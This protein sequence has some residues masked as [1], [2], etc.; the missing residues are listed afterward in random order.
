M[1]GIFGYFGKNNAF[2][3][4]LKGLK[5]LEYRGYDS[6]GIAVL[7]KKLEIRKG[8]GKV[9]EVFSRVDL[10]NLCGNIGIAHTRW[11]THGKVTK[12][13]A[14]PHLS[15]NKKVAVVHN[16]I[17]ENYQELKSFLE[18][19]GFVFYTETDT[20]VIPNLIEYEMRKGKGFEEACKDAFRMLEGSYAILAIHEDEKKIIETCNGSPLVIGVGEDEYFAASDIPAFLEFTPRVIYLHDKDF[21]VI[22]KEIKFFNLAEEKE[23]KRE[24]K[25]VEWSLEEVKKGNFEHYMLKEI[26]EQVET[27]QRAINQD[28]KILMEVAKSIREA[29]GVFLI[30]CG[31]S[32]HACLTASYLFS[33]IAKMHVNP[34]LA[35][36]FSNYEDFL[37]EKTLVIA[38]SQSG[39]TA[40]VLEAVKTAKKKGSKVISIVNVLGSS[41]HRNSDQALLMNAGPEICVLSTK[42]YTS[43]LVILTL[44]AYALAGKYEE[45]RK[46]L[47]YLWNLIYNLTSESTREHIKKL[48]EKLKDKEHLFLIGRGLQYPTALEAA[49][50]IKEVSYIH[51]EAFA[52]GELKHGTIALIENG[53]PCIVFVSEENE[54]EIIA[55]AYEIKARGGYIIGVSS[56]RNEIFDFWI[57]VPEVGETNPIC[58]IIPIQI[59]AYQLAV[60]RC[61][62]PDKPRN[63]AKSVTVK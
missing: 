52:G 30:G 39:E 31:T 14:H 9:D 38:V 32:Y 22:D 45:G 54:K 28:E 19:N 27:I 55:N 29:K 20:E 60:L 7:G 34:V 33:K 15:N 4:L 48:A 50:K 24:V 44:L 41:L 42:T 58:Q 6:A 46:K 1:C 12:E 16:G 10:E 17:V 5:M 57:K 63:L 25:S 23:V 53:T 37:T 40:D 36:E 13:N 35:S 59:L 2:P 56:K 26:S 18:S 21:V 11:A 61:L 62:D 8:V 49:L 51:A 3:I 43:Q 47:R